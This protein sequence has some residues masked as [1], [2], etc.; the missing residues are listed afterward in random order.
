MGKSSDTENA[1]IFALNTARAAHHGIHTLK[2]VS[3]GVK[4]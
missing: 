2:A 1:F 3:D 4:V